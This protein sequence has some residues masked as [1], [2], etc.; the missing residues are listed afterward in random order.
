ME[1]T[2]SWVP[3][4]TTLPERTWL[5]YRHAY[6]ISSQ[7]RMFREPRIRDL[8]MDVQGIII[9]TVTFCSGTFDHID[10]GELREPH[11]LIR[12]KLD[13]ALS[14]FFQW[15]KTISRDAAVSPIY[16]HF[17]RAV[18]DALHGVSDSNEADIA[19]FTEWRNVMAG[20]NSSGT[21]S[22]IDGILNN[23]YAERR[24]LD[25]TA[26]LCN[27]L[28]GKRILL[29][30]RAGHIGSG[31]PQMLVGDK[32]VLVSGVPAPLIIREEAETPGK[33][34]VLGPAFICGFMSWDENEKKEEE[35]VS[36]TFF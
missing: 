13:S 10:L 18:F 5:E 7:P 21:Q 8:E 4:W 17:S 25:F 9:G 29:S 6:N 19:G 11:Q 12:E 3:D 30:S 34:T 33:Y 27:M 32:I 15:L 14:Q 22:T 23:A 31:P 36:L 1:S 24:V 28:H 2:P 26:K 20:W 35:W 16:E